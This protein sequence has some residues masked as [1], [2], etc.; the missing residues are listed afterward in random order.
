MKRSIKRFA[1]G[2]QAKMFTDG[3]WRLSLPDGS[4]PNGQ[5]ANE[6]AALAA[7]ENAHTE[8]VLRCWEEGR[9]TPHGFLVPVRG[10]E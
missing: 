10:G 3:T 8:F 7:V 4:H 9:H 1:D 6:V 2:S 5:E